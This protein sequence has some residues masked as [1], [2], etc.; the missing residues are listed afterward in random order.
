MAAYAKVA[1]LALVTVA[2]SSPVPPAA[3]APPAP[4]PTTQAQRPAGRVA[5]RPRLTFADGRTA[6]AGTAFALEGARPLAIVPTH[7]VL[8][9]LRGSTV[10]RFEL[11][12]AKSK[13]PVASAIG[14][15][16]PPGAP[17][18]GLDFSTD[19]SIVVLDDVPADVARVGLSSERA[20]VGLPVD[21]IAC[22]ADGSAPEVTLSGTVTYAGAQ[23]LELMLDAVGDPRGVAGAPILARATGRAIG[24]VQTVTPGQGG[25]AL[26]RATPAESIGPKLAEVEAAAKPLALSAWRVGPARR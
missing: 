20:T 19:F 7:I 4:P 25:A 12:D 14:L 2:C 16:G 1:L 24:I 22:P 21:V 3:P 18:D 17:M 6:L 23:R 11:A 5:L 26:V 10:A 9:V 15:A 13:V 8:A